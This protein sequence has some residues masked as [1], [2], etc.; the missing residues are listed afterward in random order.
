MQ[1]KDLF[2]FAS[3]PTQW[4]SELSWFSLLGCLTGS[5]CW[6]SIAFHPLLNTQGGKAGSLW[7]PSTRAWSKSGARAVLMNESL[8]HLSLHIYQVPPH[9][10]GWGSCVWVFI[11][12]WVYFQEYYTAT[13]Y[14]VTTFQ[15]ENIYVC[16]C[17]HMCTWV[18][19]IWVFESNSTRPPGSSSSGYIL[20]ATNH[21]G[22]S[23]QFLPF[24]TSMGKNLLVYRLWKKLRD[25]YKLLFS[26]FHFQTEWWDRPAALHV[27]FTVN[28]SKN[29]EWS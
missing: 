21:K 20:A 19:Y 13:A 7:T 24:D 10:H 18:Q 3:S 26:R 5:T 6:K 4:E 8:S 28:P 14:S 2:T 9:P 29:E 12:S 25:V 22:D 11:F 15:L 27:T 23:P 1:H 17:I 16:M